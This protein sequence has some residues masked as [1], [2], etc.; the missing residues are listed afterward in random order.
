MTEKIRIGVLVSGNGSNLQSIIDAAE[1]GKIDAEIACVISNNA[2][3]FALERAKRHQ[4]P[5][6][7]SG[8]QIIL[9]QGSI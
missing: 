8:S 7:Q 5:A 9:H 1:A 2:K 3:A 4:I 6:F